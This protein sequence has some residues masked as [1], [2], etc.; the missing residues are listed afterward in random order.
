MI[1]GGGRGDCRLHNYTRRSEIGSFKAI[2]LASSGGGG[3]GGG[4]GSS[5][6][7][8]SSHLDTAVLGG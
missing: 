3:G 2:A 5:I 8:P 7:K 1:E 4:G 6:I